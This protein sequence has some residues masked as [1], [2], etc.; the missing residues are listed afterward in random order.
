VRPPRILLLLCCAALAG[1]VVPGARSADD[2]NA[3]LLAPSGQCGGAADQLNLDQSAAQQAMTCLTNYARTQSGLVPLQPNSALND[4]GQAK[5]AADLSCAEFSHTPCG[6]PF[7]AVFETYIR[8]ATSYGVGENIAWGTGSF[9]TPR[10]TMNGWLHSTGHRENILRADYR[11]LG[12]G[13]LADQTFQGYAGATLWSQEFGVRT[14]GSPPTS[15]PTSSPPPANAQPVSAPAATK[16]VLKP[17]LKKQPTRH[18]KTR[19]HLHLHR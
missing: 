1:A 18:R 14:P 5:L 9:G 15:G 3:A 13:Y 16:P 11:E 19:R 10:Q 4:A 17:V 6:S 8:G 12:I 7:T 2:P